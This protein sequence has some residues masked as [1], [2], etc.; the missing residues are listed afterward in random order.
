MVDGSTSFPPYDQ[1]IGAVTAAL[2]VGYRLIDTTRYS[3]TEPDIAAGI[4]LSGISR[5]DVFIVTK[6]LQRAHA[7]EDMVNASLQQSLE[8]LCS[9]YIDLYMVHNPRAGR[10]KQVWPSL[11]QLRK[12]GFIRALGVASFGVDQLEGMRA[13]G[14]ELV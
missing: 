11:I 12:Q 2:K 9:S 8:S 14:L 13:A 7:S 6:L 3:N 5:S 10:I 4:R 1:L